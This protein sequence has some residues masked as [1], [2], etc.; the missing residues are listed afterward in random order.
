[1]H[2]YFLNA[3]FANFVPN[4]PYCRAI[5]ICLLHSTNHLKPRVYLTNYTFCPQSIFMCTVWFSEKKQQLF[6]YTSFNLLVFITDQCLCCE[7]GMNLKTI[8]ARLNLLDRAIAQAVS[9]RPVTAQALVW[10]QG[11]TC[12]NCGQRVTWIGFSPNTSVSSFQCQ[13]TGAAY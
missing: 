2:I 10:S 3:S 4:C 5:K 7:V 9:R 13:S 12:E 1:M 6:P 8:P 11:I